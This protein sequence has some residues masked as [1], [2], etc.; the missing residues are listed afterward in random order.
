M[1]YGSF[2]YGEAKYGDSAHDTQLW[3][4]LIDWDGDGRYDG[5]NEAVHLTDMRV[6]RGRT[7]QINANGT[8]FQPVDT[9]RLSIEL[10]NAD[11]R[12]HPLNPSSPLYPYVRPGV[13]LQLLTRLPVSGTMYPVF[14]GR[15]DDVQPISGS[16]ERVRITALD[17]LEWLA[18][19]EV[20]L[21]IQA[22]KKPEELIA[23]ILQEADWPWG[24]DLDT[25]SDTVPW[26]WSPDE[27]NSLDLINDLV[28]GYMGTFFVGADGAATFRPRSAVFTAS[29]LRLEQDQLGREITFQSPWNVVKNNIKVLSHPRSP[30]ATAVVWSYGQKP[31]IAPGETLDLW[32]TYS[33]NGETVPISSHTVPVAGTDYA[34]NTQ[35]DGGGTDVTADIAVTVDVYGGSVHYQVTNNGAVTAILLTCQLRGTPLTAETAQIEV[36]DAASRALYGPRTLKIDSQFLQDP[37]VNIDI[38]N[39]IILMLAY[40]Q[41]FPTGTLTNRPEIQYSVDLFRHL[42]LI[43]DQMRI[44][45]AYKL[46]YIE[47][48]WQSE[49]GQVSSSIFGF[50]PEN[51]VLGTVWTFPAQMGIDT[52]F[53]F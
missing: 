10:D 38:A 37:N 30:Q 40:P 5:F 29:E 52:I 43:V 13:R 21:R 32:G 23:T 14:T 12:Y 47:H 11:G 24:S 9:G 1:R 18:G 51:G 4:L 28:N 44:A 26:F 17:G 36:S 15:I 20:R 41:F 16:Y 48:Q 33:Y 46:A 7:M 42:D 3:A 35:E 25:S 22:N 27:A 45:G 2:H 50:E 8:G 19:A 39:Y 53:A 49:T 34:A 6:M 31:S